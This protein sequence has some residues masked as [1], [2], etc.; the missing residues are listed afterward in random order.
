MAGFFRTAFSNCLNLAGS[1]FSVQKQQRDRGS[2][3]KYS[4]E[5]SH[6]CGSENLLTST[7]WRRWK[8]SQLLCL[9]QHRILEAFQRYLCSSYRGK[10]NQKAKLNV[11]ENLS[12]SADSVSWATLFSFS[13]VWRRPCSLA[14]CFSEYLNSGFRITIMNAIGTMILHCLSNKR[15]GFAVKS[16]R[17]LRKFTEYSIW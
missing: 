11:L 14:Q 3:F 1:C 4:N 6:L 12:F 16:V 10:W 5:R 7:L 17:P 2:F 8:S 15:A 9:R 13:Q